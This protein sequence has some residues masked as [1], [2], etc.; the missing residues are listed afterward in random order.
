M[1]YYL[2]EKCIQVATIGTQIIGKNKIAMKKMVFF[3]TFEAISTMWEECRKL[4]KVYVLV[5]F[6]Q[7]VSKKRYIHEL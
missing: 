7:I 1:Y 6:Y 5:H 2:I 3:F 4:K